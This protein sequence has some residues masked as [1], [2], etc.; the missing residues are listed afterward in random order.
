M[1]INNNTNSYISQFNLFKNYFV[2]GKE[3]SNFIC[4]AHDDKT[5]SLSIS[6]SKDKILLNCHALCSPESI[7]SSVKLTMQSLFLKSNNTQNVILK[8]YN[9]TDEHGVLI[10]QTVRYAYKKFRQRRPDSA[11]N[12]LWNLKDIQL[13]LYNLPAIIKSDLVYIVEGEKDADNLINLGLAATTS[14][15]GAGK[16]RPEF[17]A[18]FNNK[19]VIIIPDL[20]ESGANHA[21]MIANNIIA[22]TLSVKIVKLP[23]LENKGDISDFLLLHKDTSSDDILLL[24]HSIVDTTPVFAK[25]SPTIVVDRFKPYTAFDLL[26]LKFAPVEWAIPNI[27]PR[28]LGVLGGKPKIGKSFLALNLAIACASGENALT[29]I[30]VDKQRVL[31]LA[32]EDTQRRLQDRLIALVAND[33]SLQDLLFLNEIK[34]FG[35]GGY[36]LL[37]KLIVESNVKFIIIDT[38]ALIKSL[39]SSNSYSDD[40]NEASMLKKLADKYNITILLIHHLRK[41]EAEDIFDN[42][43]GTTGLTGAADTLLILKKERSNLEASLFCTGRDISESEFALTFDPVHCNWTFNGSADEMRLTTARDDIITIISNSNTP[44]TCKEI[45]EALDKNYKTTQSILY[46]LMKEKLIEKNANNKYHMR[47]FSF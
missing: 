36:E 45:S 26:G 38:F 33:N 8:V 29:N 20:D 31:Y 2:Q 30:A 41:A 21:L 42:F 19:S 35:Q 32:L 24:L 34:R 28:G 13:Y 11:G 46:K 7:L 1:S 15:M 17:N 37:E 5:A 22:I 10:H 6:L 3:T 40:Y 25:P 27:L 9:Y 39:T 43:S 18:Y 44:L 12:W 47:T 14:P 16:W 4:P 23:G